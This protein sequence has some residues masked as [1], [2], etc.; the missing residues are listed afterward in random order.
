MHAQSTHILRDFSSAFAANVRTV[1]ALR[2]RQPVYNSAG[3]RLELKRRWRD[4]MCARSCLTLRDPMDCSP[5][6]FS[7]HGIFQAR[8]LE[9]VVTSFSKGSSPPRD[10]TIVSCVSCNGRQILYHCTAWKAMSPVL[11]EISIN[12]HTTSTH[13]ASSSAVVLHLDCMSESPGGVWW[14]LIP[15]LYPE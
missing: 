5:P 13:P 3:R 15:G 9:W 2:G 6:D 14:I 4:L 7:V 11:L 8:M 10:Q 12:K 1:N